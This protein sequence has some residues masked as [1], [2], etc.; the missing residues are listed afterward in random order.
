MDSRQVCPALALKTVVL[1]G[2][3]LSLFAARIC[4]FRS[5]KQLLIASTHHEKLSQGTIAGR[6]KQKQTN[7]KEETG[8]SLACRE[9]VN[10]EETTFKTETKKPLGLSAGKDGNSKTWPKGKTRQGGVRMR[11]RNF[12]SLN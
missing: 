2:I 9:S 8:E 7:K 4:F 12:D 1:S 6:K 5:S 3:H 10:A 11:N